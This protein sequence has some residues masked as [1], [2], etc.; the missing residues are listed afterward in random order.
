M[1]S[2]ISCAS[3][4]RR[5]AALRIEGSRSG[6]P[7]AGPQPTS[8]ETAGRSVGGLW[9]AASGAAPARMRRD[10]RYVDMCIMSMG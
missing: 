3:A 1:I 10:M 9:A 8:K 6:P 5:D 2:E 7:A 4:A